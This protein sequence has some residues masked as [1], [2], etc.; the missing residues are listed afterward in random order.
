MG[1]AFVR[2]ANSKRKDTSAFHQCRIDSY[3]NLSRW[4]VEFWHGS[5]IFL[6]L[7]EEEKFLWNVVGC[8]SCSRRSIEIL[9]HEMFREPIVVAGVLPSHHEWTLIGVRNNCWLRGDFCV[10]GELFNE[11]P[12]LSFRFD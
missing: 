2:T 10:L 3:L 1:E 7:M 6:L 8:E 5:S 11:N 4:A 12:N 9:N